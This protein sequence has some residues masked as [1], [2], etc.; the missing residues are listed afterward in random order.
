MFALSKRHQIIIGL[1]LVCLMALT[2]GHHF[3][4]QIALPSASLAVFFLA[5]FYLTNKL[6]FPLLLLEAALID[7]L[8]ITVGGVSSYC[9][10]PAYVLLI[11]A[12]GTLYLAGRWYKNHYQLNWSTLLPLGGSLVV[13]SVIS[14]IFSSGGFYVFSGRFTELSV[15]EFAQRFATYYP[16]QLAT[17]LT[18][19]AAAALCHVLVASLLNMSKQQE[20]HS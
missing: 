5:G 3:A 20:H 1:L 19:V 4:T 7:Y 18:Y 14:E 15:T 12:Y 16:S 6:M 13:A 11:P 10:S 8:A 17:L 9:V 2:R